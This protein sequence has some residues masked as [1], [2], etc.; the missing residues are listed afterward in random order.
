ML[1]LREPAQPWA[2]LPL[3]RVCALLGINRGSFYRYGSGM[4]PTASASL[5]A[6]TERDLLEA[7][8]GLVL[9][10]PGYGYRRVT[11]ALKRNGWKVNHKRVLRLMRRESLLCQLRRRW[12]RTTDSEHGWRIYPNLLPER[13]WQKL[14]GVNQAWMADITY[15][16]LPRGFAYLAALLDGYSRKI[17]GWQL[18]QD[19]DARV[20]LRAL[21]KAL[22]LRQPPSGWI[23]HSDQ[24][25]QYACRDY[26]KRLMEAEA[27][28]SMSAKGTPRENAQI[29]SFFRTL[30][31][32][33]VYLNDY[34]TYEHAERAVDRFIGDVYNAKRLHSAL[35][36]CPPDEFEQ[37]RPS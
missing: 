12:A 35:G 16:R 7:I 36:Y 14:T 5:A 27:R 26:V 30:K 10:F 13:G 15:I 3:Q 29:E 32:E 19:I 33:E 22:K 23:H 2:D 1:D 34:Q 25:V 17:V 4:E 9:A 11:H 28:V 18:G 37:G 31:H 20:V 6:W 8:E 21:D 24:G